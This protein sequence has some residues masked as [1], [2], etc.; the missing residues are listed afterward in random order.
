MF[1]LKCFVAV[2]LVFVKYI[3]SQF[4]TFNASMFLCFRQ[5]MFSQFFAFNISMSLCFQHV[6]YKQNMLISW[7]LLLSNYP[8]VSFNQRVLSTYLHSDFLYNWTCFFDLLKSFLIVSLFLDFFT[9]HLLLHYLFCC[10]YSLFL[11]VS[12]LSV[13]NMHTLLLCFSFFFIKVN[14]ISSKMHKL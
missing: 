2:L 11:Y 13:Y 6:S 12:F 14:L 10:L 4:F 9:S 7:I 1:V 5:Y 8:S 3:F